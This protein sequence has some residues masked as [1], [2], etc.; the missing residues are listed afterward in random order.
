MLWTTDCRLIICELCLKSM[1]TGFWDICRSP[2][3]PELQCICSSKPKLLLKLTSNGVGMLWFSDELGRSL[4]TTLHSP[5]MK[6]DCSRF[7]DARRSAP[8]MSFMNK[9]EFFG[10]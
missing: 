7:M 6:S 5:E 8:Y 4:G 10:T 3:T 9:S 1:K 2:F